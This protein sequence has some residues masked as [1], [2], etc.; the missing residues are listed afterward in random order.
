MAA[1][2][3]RRLEQITQGTPKCLLKFNGKPILEYQLDSLVDNGIKDIIVI[4]GYKGFMIREFIQNHDVF[5][6]L[7]IIFVENN[8]YEN[9]GTAY[10]WWHA[11]DHIRDVETLIHFNADLIFSPSLIKKIIEHD[12]ENAICV[13]KKVSL[14]T[15]MMQVVLDLDSDLMLSM[16]KRVIG[17]AHGKGVGVAKFSK[18]AVDFILNRIEKGLRDGNKN[19][20]FYEI[21]GRA[22]AEYDFFGVSIGKEFFSE[23]NTPEDYEGINKNIRE[24]SRKAVIFDF[25]G[26]II[27][28]E[29][30]RYQTYRQLFFE[31]Y[32]VEL[33]EYDSEII[34]RTM[35]KNLTYFLNKHNLLGDLSELANRRKE[36]LFETFSKEENI[37]PVKGLFKLLKKL[38]SNN[39]RM[40]IASSSNKNFIEKILEHLGIRNFFE[41]VIGGE[42]VS[43]SKPHP[44]IFIECAKQ[45]GCEREDCVVLEDSV[46]GIYAAKAAE[47]KVI[48]ITTSLEKEKLNAADKV[49][50][51]LNSIYILDLINL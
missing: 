50:D 46:N 20:I 31:K 16:K 2:M 40:A 35:K 48:A 24:I 4:I 36:L 9:T 26:V 37:L 44:E 6:N 41:I 45:L 7:N 29:R 3:A 34:G 38:K 33:P 39:V 22:M 49:V 43:N 30:L 11:R 32:S 21:L 12:S 17:G 10:S 23:I 8:E 15:S 5:R 14:N 28:S 51:N 42:S 47:M 27:D 1:G 13:D 25:D 18:K 19:E